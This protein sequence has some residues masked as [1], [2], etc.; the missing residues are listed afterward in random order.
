[1][2]SKMATVGSKPG[3]GSGSSMLKQ[4]K[5]QPQFEDRWE[6]MRPTV[7]KLL[8]QE[9]VS[10]DEWHDLFWEVYSVCV[11]DDKGAEKVNDALKHDIVEFVQQSKQRVLHDQDESALLKAYIRE[12]GKYF[13]QCDYLPKPFKPLESAASGKGSSGQQKKASQQNEDS[14]VRKLMLESWSHYIFSKIKQKL[15]DSAMG[16]VLAERNGEAFEKQLVIGVRESYVNLCLNNDDRLQIYKENFEKAYLDATEAFYKAQAPNY[17]A[18]NGVQNYMKYA[19]SKLKEEE[20]RAQ[21]YLDT[22]KGSTSISLLTDCCVECLVSVFKEEILRECAPMI[23]N[24]ETDKL[25]LMLKL[26]DRV[27]E[28]INPMLRDLEQ[29][30]IEAG[31]A[32]MV[33]AAD[34][35]TTDSEKYVERLLELFHRFSSLV[36]QAFN[37]DPRFLTSRD[38][39]YKHVVNDTKVFRLELPTKNKSAVS[40]CQPES[41]C[42]ELLANYCDMLLRKTPLSKKLTSEEIE[43]K[44]RNVLL[45][46]KYVQNKDVFMRYHKA[47]LTRRLILDTSADSEKEENMVEWLREVGMPA[48]YVNKLARMFQDI[49]VSEDLNQ[50]FKE[51]HRNNYGNV[52]DNMNIKILNAGAWSRSSE[53]VPVS[54]PVELEDFIPEV[55]DF[56]RNKH[57]GRKLQWH[58]LMSNGIITLKNEVGMFDL[59]VTTFQMGVLFAWNQRPHDKISLENLRLA[60]ELP[61]HELRRTLWSLV[62]FAKLKRQLILMH[63]EAKSPKE[64]S[65]GTVFWVNQEFAV[66]KNG[67]PQKR[68]KINLIGRLQLS[69][70]RSAEEDKEGIVQLRILRTQEAIVKIMKMRKKL[71]NAQLQTELVE[72][73]KNMFLPQKKMIKE[74]IEWLI[75]HKYMKRDEGDINTFIYLA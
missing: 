50:A 10:R 8:R 28:G 54:L 11:W 65:D 52:A 15:Q 22:S 45:V 3:G 74:Q 73:L 75:E 9:N 18:E 7:L 35:I 51:L 47:H 67:K 27:P 16:L 53:R 69:T 72:I 63:P 39:A 62:A 49:K 21:R 58:H 25:N 48:D 19:D 55:E 57:S 17:L 36:K 56:Y 68:G 43:S 41:R 4:D 23:R 66:I 70:E 26:M 59:E 1:M 61:D 30:I 12:W 32:D 60:T 29:H 2:H 20:A 34:V 33:A 31:L 14:P 71:S 13:T 24:N 40:K 44:L 6:G 42:P 5:S 64:F 46:L 38:K 37:D